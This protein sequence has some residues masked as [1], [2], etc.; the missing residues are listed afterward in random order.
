MPPGVFHF[1]YTTLRDF[2]ISFIQ[3]SEVLWISDKTI[4]ILAPGLLGSGSAGSGP[5]GA[6]RA[7]GKISKKIFEELSTRVRFLASFEWLV[8]YTI[9]PNLKET[10]ADSN[11]AQIFF[12]RPRTNMWQ[13][14]DGLP[15]L[16]ASGRAYRKAREI[17]KIQR[18]INGLRAGWPVQNLSG[19]LKSSKK[20]TN[21]IKVLRD[22]CSELE[23][24]SKSSLRDCSAAARLASGGSGP[25]GPA[26]APKTLQNHGKSW[27]IDF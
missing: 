17:K 20:S 2:F 22:S 24:S 15:H 11:R 26:G 10:F 9:I 4:Q 21:S 3:P 19:H 16:W 6:S 12:L 25:A 14:T 5:A 23:K 7:G 8:L 13:S 27:E 18:K 1:L